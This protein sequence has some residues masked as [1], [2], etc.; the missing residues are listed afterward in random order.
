VIP[1]HARGALCEGNLLGMLQI[2]SELRGGR[3]TR[4]WVDLQTTQD[5]FL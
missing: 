4:L 1:S 3:V 5:D 2:E